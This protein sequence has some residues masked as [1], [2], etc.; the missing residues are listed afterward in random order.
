MINQAAKSKK[1][2]TEQKRCQ[3]Q[4]LHKIKMAE[5]EHFAGKKTRGNS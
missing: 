4:I 1:E 5:E 2:T 3:M